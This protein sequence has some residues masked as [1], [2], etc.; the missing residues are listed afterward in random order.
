VL[1]LVRATVKRLGKEA[2]TYRF[3]QEEKR[4]LA[5]IVYRYRGQG[6]RTSENEITR[7]AVNWLVEDY[8]RKGT[9]SIL[10]QVLERLN[11]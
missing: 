8:R 7:I 1:D 4:A 11:E 10:A 9:G 6:V 5:E 2:A 3:T